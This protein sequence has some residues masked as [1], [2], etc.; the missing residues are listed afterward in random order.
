MGSDARVCRICKQ[1]L[2][3]HDMVALRCCHALLERRERALYKQLK[4]GAERD[5]LESKLVSR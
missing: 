5:A 3:H 1:A 2:D 4:L